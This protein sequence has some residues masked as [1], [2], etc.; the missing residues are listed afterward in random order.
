MDSRELRARGVVSA[1][2]AATSASGF[3]SAESGVRRRAD[4]S[5]AAR[6][7]A[8]EAPSHLRAYK[9]SLA[10]R[11]PAPRGC[12]SL[13]FGGNDG[14]ALRRGKRAVS[15]RLHVQHG[16]LDHA[17][18]RRGRR[19]TR[20]HGSAARVTDTAAGSGKTRAPRTS[21]AHARAHFAIGR[22][23]MGRRRARRLQRLA[24]AASRA[25]SRGGAGSSIARKPWRH[26]RLAAAC[27][28]SRL[29]GARAP[30]RRVR[31]RRA[32]AARRAASGASASGHSAMSALAL[33]R[34]RA[35]DEVAHRLRVELVPE[36]APRLPGRREARHAVWAKR[37]A[38]SRLRPL[39]WLCAQPTSTRCVA[40]AEADAAN[41]LSSAATE[42][43][44]AA[45][46]ASTSPARFFRPANAPAAATKTPSVSGRTPAFLPG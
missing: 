43:L 32:P 26:K 33:H 5:S 13:M 10:N 14:N 34:V 18:V 23:E 3:G 16:A 38:P 27:A 17:Q 39:L 1:R 9:S 7:R 24:S 40:G 41:A 25:E 44:A 8:G 4:A 19:R 12:G 35:G 45:R 30:P 6:A 22:V 37:V 11:H 31:H 21:R 46:S 28:A 15:R 42:S 20:V 2:A 29:R 36:R